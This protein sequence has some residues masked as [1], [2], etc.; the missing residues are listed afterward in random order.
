MLAEIFLVRM[1]AL[2]RHRSPEPK[3]PTQDP[4]FVPYKPPTTRK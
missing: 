3:R 4:R 1:E 2:M